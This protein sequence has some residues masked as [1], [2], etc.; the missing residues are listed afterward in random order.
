MWKKVKALVEPLERFSTTLG[1]KGP[2]SNATHTGGTS[3]ITYSTKQQVSELQKPSAVKIFANKS[4]EQTRLRNFL[5]E[6]F[7]FF[8]AFSLQPVPAFSRTPLRIHKP[9]GFGVI[10]QHAFIHPVGTRN[11]FCRGFRNFS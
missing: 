10:S 7:S 2:K 9:Q 1:T 6:N 3:Q 5:L 11:I 4:S 8:K